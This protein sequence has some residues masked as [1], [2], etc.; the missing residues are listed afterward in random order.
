MT[1][2]RDSNISHYDQNVRD[3]YSD[4]SEKAENLLPEDPAP[5]VLHPFEE[6]IPERIERRLACKA[7]INGLVIFV[8]FEPQF[9]GVGEE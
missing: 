9:I 8:R 1:G 4:K 2:W 5:F 7:I 3:Q 6:E